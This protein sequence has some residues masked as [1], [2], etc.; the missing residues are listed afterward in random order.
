MEN[1]LTNLQ[2]VAPAATS[3][4][5]EAPK[6]PKLVET[7]DF[8]IIKDSITGEVDKKEKPDVLNL[9][10]H[11]SLVPFVVLMAWWLLKEPTDKHDE[12]GE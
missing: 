12:G 9:W 2:E 4:T 8:E 1:S 10:Q 11:L 3:A 7:N 6:T 5:P